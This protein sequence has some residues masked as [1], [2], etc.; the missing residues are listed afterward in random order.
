MFY[1]SSPSFCKFNILIHEFTTNEE[2]FPIDIHV[3]C[4]YMAVRMALFLSKYSLIPFVKYFWRNKVGFEHIFIFLL[5]LRLRFFEHSSD[6]FHLSLLSIS[7][8]ECLWKMCLF[9]SFNIL[10]ASLIHKWNFHVVL[11]LSLRIGCTKW[12]KRKTNPFAA[13]LMFYMGSPCPCHSSHLL[14]C[15]QDRENRTCM[16]VWFTMGMTVFKYRNLG[17]LLHVHESWAHERRWKTK[18]VINYVISPKVE[19]RQIKGNYTS[20]V[21]VIIVTRCFFNIKFNQR[22]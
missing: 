10:K 4:F 1:T 8:K 21:K 15:K 14:L 18:E 16:H 19:Q 7:K 2:L 11:W 5:L 6:E 13:L 12:Q 9:F 22:N 17:L 3:H 20:T